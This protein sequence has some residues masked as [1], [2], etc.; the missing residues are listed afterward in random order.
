MSSVWNATHSGVGGARVPSTG[1]SVV[2]GHAAVGRVATDHVVP[3]MPPHLATL[4]HPICPWDSA[5][6]W[7]RAF[8]PLSFTRRS[9]EPQLQKLGYDTTIEPEP[10]LCLSPSM[11]SDGRLRFVVRPT[12]EVDAHGRPEARGFGTLRSGLETPNYLY[13]TQKLPVLP[14]ARSSEQGAGPE[15]AGYSPRA[16]PLLT[17]AHL[18]RNVQDD[19]APCT[20]TYLFSPRRL[21]NP[22]VWKTMAMEQHEQVFGAKSHR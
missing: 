9:N 12:T 8:P 5:T 4:S 13:T 1:G 3:A 18:R 19:V 14:P 11:S 15:P 21:G 6:R 7:H 10:D 2:R 16:A 17:P 20:K 22:N